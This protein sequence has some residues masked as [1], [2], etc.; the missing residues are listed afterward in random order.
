MVGGKFS[1]R[2]FIVRQTFIGSKQNENIYVD[3]VIEE[4]YITKAI[5]PVDNRIVWIFE[6]TEEIK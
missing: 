1:T 5:I 4:G 2:K 6:K 3:M